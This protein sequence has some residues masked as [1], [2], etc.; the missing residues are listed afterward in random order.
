MTFGCCE[1]H[2][3]QRVRQVAKHDE[4]DACRSTGIGEKGEVLFE[5]KV[6]LMMK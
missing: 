6:I 4:A 2:E 3:R 1:E 5:T